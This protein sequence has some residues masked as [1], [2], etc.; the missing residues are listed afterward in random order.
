MQRNPRIRGGFFSEE[1]VHG[2]RPSRGR[3]DNSSADDFA[4]CHKMSVLGWGLRSNWG[5]MVPTSGG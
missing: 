3:C 1:L 4:D 5:T 2:L